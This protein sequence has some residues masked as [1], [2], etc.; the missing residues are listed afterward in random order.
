VLDT[1]SRIPGQQIQ[2]PPA[3]LDIPV[4]VTRYEPGNIQLQLGASPPQG[5][6]LIVS[7]NYFPGWSASV[8]GRSALTD[9]VQYNLIGVQ[10]PAN[11]KQVTLRF[12]DAAYERGKMITLIALIFSIAL[13]VA[14]FVLPGRRQEAA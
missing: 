13:L 1:N 3:P 8:D 2:A 7:E 11:A 4:R 5:S 12:D 6:A 14:G 9:R 10:L